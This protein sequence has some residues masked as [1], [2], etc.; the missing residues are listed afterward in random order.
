[1]TN[2]FRESQITYNLTPRRD[3]L[4]VDIAFHVASGPQARVGT[5]DLTG[6]AGMSAADFRHHAHLRA[7]AKVNHE[8]ANRALAG[9]LK[10]YQSQQRLEAEIKLESQQY[11]AQSHRANFRFSANRGPEVKVLVEGA[12]MSAARVKRA[13]PIFEEGSVDED[14]LN[15][16]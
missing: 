5:V 2:G 11:A 6:D 10:V 3:E 13:I 7:G 9:V 12:S 15:E 1:E 4:L 16:G 8:T 14:L